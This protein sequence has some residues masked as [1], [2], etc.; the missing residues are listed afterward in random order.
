MPSSPERE[1]H[2]EWIAGAI[3]T[4]LAFYWR[5]DDPKHLIGAMARD[6]VKILEGLPQD[7]IERARLRYLRDEPRRRPTPGA[8]YAMA[9]EEMPRPAIVHRL[10]PPEPDRP[11][12]CD[13]DRATEIL[14]EFGFAPKRFGGSSE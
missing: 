10:P 3:A 12:P 14:R 6:W 9:R 8:I 2:R 13:P 11:P 7:A 5:D 1:A 4:L